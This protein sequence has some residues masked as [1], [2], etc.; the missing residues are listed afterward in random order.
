MGLGGRSGSQTHLRNRAAILRGRI[1]SWGADALLITNFRDIRYLTGFVGDDSWALVPARSGRLVVISDFRFQEQI[2]R[3]APHVTALMRK[4]TLTE[5][6]AKLV[7]RRGYTK[8]ALQAEHVSLAQRKALVNKLG[9]GRLIAVD[10]GLIQ[11]RSIKDSKEIAAI[12]RAIRVTEEAYR[13]TCPFIKPGVAERDLAA[14]LEFEMRRL[15]ADGSAFPSIVAADANASLPHAIPGQ[16]K[17][18]AGGTVLFDWGA[19]VDGY[20]GD[21]TR[22]VALGAFKPAIRDIYQ[23][24]LAA[25]R[26]AIEAIGP[27][28]QLKDVDQVARDLITKAGYGD[29]FGHGLG[30]GLGLEVHEQPMFS[31][32]SKGNLEAGHVLTVE[33]GIYLPGLGGVRIEDDVLVTA[34]GHRVLSRLPT[35]LESAI[36]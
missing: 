5:T 10:D 27:G 14:H 31:W 18:R 24:V 25:Q 15:G 9:A 6:L 7:E 30:H 20:C 29:R 12:G 17:I 1:R 8:I 35:D 13:R 19:V 36:I 22:V 4:W 33:P 11:Q 26:A 2:Q 23:I 3:E 21:L 28:R 16:R 32:R 34:D